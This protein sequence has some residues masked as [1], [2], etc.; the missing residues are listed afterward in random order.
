M[1]YAGVGPGG[2]DPP[3]RGRRRGVGRPPPG[4]YNA[5]AAAAGG[6]HPPPV[7]ARRRGGGLPPRWQG[8]RAES[9][10]RRL[11]NLP[12]GIIRHVLIRNRGSQNLNFSISLRGSQ[13]PDW[14]HE[15]EGVDP[16]WG[17]P[18]P[19]GGGHPPPPQPAAAG[20]VYPP[21]SESLRRRRRRGGG[22]NPPEPQFAYVCGQI[23]FYEKA[24]P[25]YIRR[26]V[27]GEGP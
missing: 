21:H 24:T 16:P 18:P 5:T 9:P 1:P 10:S 14:V 26:G 15:L 12:H 11:C 2:F 25:A 3:Q 19:R 23:H 8:R 27:R 6:G 7:T 17:P 22:R 20:G 13:R 4:Q